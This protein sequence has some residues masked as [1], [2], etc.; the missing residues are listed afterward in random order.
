MDRSSQV[1][2]VIKPSDY[3]TLA[4]ASASRFYKGTLTQSGQL[5]LIL[6]ELCSLV[7]VKIGLYGSGMLK[8]ASVSRFYKGILARSGQ[9]LLILR[10]LCLLVVVMTK[11]YKYGIPT[12]V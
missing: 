2:A 7:V 10:E 1:A 6:T 12:L 11:L 3:G 9:L 5:L 8:L 4:L